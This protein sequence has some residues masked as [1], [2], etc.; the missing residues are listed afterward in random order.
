MLSTDQRAVLMIRFR[1]IQS[2]IR[3]W[4]TM[5]GIQREENLLASLVYLI[6]LTLIFGAWLAGMMFL[7]SDVLV[8]GAAPLLASTGLSLPDLVPPLGALL[9]LAWSAYTIYKATLRSPL[10]FSKIDAAL[11]CQTPADRRIVALVWLA[12]TWIR[13]LV[14]L[15]VSASTVGFALYELAAGEEDTL[16]RAVPLAAAA[17]KPLIIL[18]PLHLGLIALVW[19]VGV[20]RLRKGGKHSS[21]M[22]AV[23]AIVLVFAVFLLSATATHLFFPGVSVPLA[24]LASAFS[25]PIKTAY[26]GGNGWL[27]LSAALGLAACSLAVLWW[28]S[29]TLNL[30]RAAQ[31]THDL[32]TRRTAYLF[33][34]SELLRQMRRRK[35]LGAAHPQSRIPIYPGTWSLTW[36]HLVQSQRTSLLASA[37][38]WVSLFLLTIAVIAAGAFIEDWAYLLPPIFYWMMAIGQKTSAGLKKD[39][40]RW[41]LLQSLPFPS[42]RIL[43]HELLPSITFTTLLTWMALWVCSGLGIHTQPII[44]YTLPVVIAG[45]A[46]SHVFDML[47]QAETTALLKGRALDAGLI[48]LM[49]SLFWAAVP[50]A[51]H[52]AVKSL[53][54]LPVVGVFAVFLLG[55]PFIVLLFRLLERQ[56]MQIG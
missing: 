34:R 20:Y 36:K 3:Y 43:L 42:H 53:N 40:G 37:W 38:S 33:G 46:L 9:F 6:Y 55:V 41:W 32:H 8:N 45:I 51:I 2:R 11:L 24:P 48:G 47:H 7:A 25:L 31:E 28:I 5:V 19:I 39:V 52:A 56:F 15:C 1:H 13:Q 12:E 30:S 22:Q 14:I 29:D 17:L 26:F 16:I 23:R 18:I 10:I 49:L 35:R 21:A 54:L 27:G 44:V 50:A 4:L